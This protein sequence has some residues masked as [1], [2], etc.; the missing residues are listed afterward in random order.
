MANKDQMLNSKNDV[1][2]QGIIVHKF[3]TPKIAILTINTGNAS[4]VPNYPKILFFGELRT[5]VENDFNIRDHVTIT[6]NLQSSKPKE[7]VK[8]QIMQA[9]FGESIEVSQSIIENAFGVSSDRTSRR[10]FVNTFKIAGEVMSIDYSSPRIV[11]VVI[12]TLKNNRP[13]FVR[14]DYYTRDPEKFLTQIHPRDF[15]CAVGSIQTNKHTNARGET[16]YFENYVLSEVE[17]SSD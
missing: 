1:L 5:R 14:F 7:G 11:H 16:R 13:S 12:K 2:I 8:N 6:G 15:V 4:A 9:I 17:K 10:E 3:V